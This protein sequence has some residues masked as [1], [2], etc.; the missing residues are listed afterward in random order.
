VLSVVVAALLLLAVADA[1]VL[2]LVEVVDATV[3]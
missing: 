3:A 1:E 2:Q